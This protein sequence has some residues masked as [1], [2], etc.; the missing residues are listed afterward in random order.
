MTDFSELVEDYSRHPVPEEKTVHGVHLGIMVIGVMIT[1]PAF[2][3]G[4]QLGASLGLS[5]ALAGISLGALLLTLITGATGTVGARTH[6]STSMINRYTFGTSGALIINTILG[7]TALGWYSVIIAL[8]GEAAIGGL[9]DLGIEINSTQVATVIGSVLTV[10][11]TI[12]GFKALDKLALA[13]VP[14]MLMFLFLVLYLATRDV[15]LQS[16]IS[17][18][19][20]DTSFD[21]GETASLIVGSFIVGAT[22]FPDMCRY[23]RSIPHVWL[24]ALLSYGI[25]YV[26]V[27]SLAMIP[28]IATGESDLIAIIGLVGLGVFGFAMLL[29]STLTTVAYNLYSGSLAAAALFQRVAKWKLVIVLGVAS[30]IAAVSGANEYFIDWITILSLT[31]PPIGGVYVVDWLLLRRNQEMSEPPAGFAWPALASCVV[32]SAVAYLTYLGKLELTAVPAIDAMLTA[33]VMYYLWSSFLG[34]VS[35]QS[36]E[37]SEKLSD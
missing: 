12:F 19:S 21:L 31:I 26:V 14:V 2:V 33:V 10:L 34:R 18:T 28:S 29:F 9:Q 16:I 30:T 35:A 17:S 3:L 7:I 23:A 25:G 22:L 6:L 37:L 27:L 15:S 13:A 24:G 11:I 5:R 4:S 1:V 32:G 20:T 36:R 8:F